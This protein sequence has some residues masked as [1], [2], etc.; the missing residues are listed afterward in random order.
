MSGT[1][2]RDARK[3]P[4]TKE[5]L[6]KIV[7]RWKDGETLKQ[8]AAS[9]GLKY[10]TFLRQTRHAWGTEIK[11][12]ESKSY[13]KS[14]LNAHQL[15]EAVRRWEHGERLQEISRDYGVS[16]SK[17]L[18]QTCP[19][20]IKG[21]NSGG[22]LSI[23]ALRNAMLRRD[24]G[25]LLS[26]IASDLN[27]SQL[28]LRLGM[29]HIEGSMPPLP[30]ILL[31]ASRLTDALMQYERGEPLTKL[32]KRYN[33]SRHKLR[34]LFIYECWRRGD[35]IEEIAER[36]NRTKYAVREYILKHRQQEQF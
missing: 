13:N 24:Q 23:E 31:N 4:L 8:I 30:C 17:V 33:I 12:P 28:A 25:E 9:Y 6:V 18:E 3:Q 20:R 11:A 32:A 15:A 10:A 27:V 34:S 29:K 1:L 16:Y 26:T 2:F 21:K 5:E 7:Q 19:Y 35:S 36:F 14:E 22:K